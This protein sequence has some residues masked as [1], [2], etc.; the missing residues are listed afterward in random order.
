[1]AA[2]VD[3]AQQVGIKL[4]VEALDEERRG[5]LP[6]REPAQQSRHHLKRGCVATQRRV[7]APAISRRAL[8]ATIA[9][10]LLAAVKAPAGPIA[11]PRFGF[12]EVARKAEALAG[13][14]YTP[15][16]PL[17]AQVGTWSY[18]DYRRIQ[19]KL[20]RTLW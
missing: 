2:G 8:I 4:S 9:G 15:G 17:P 10:S 7:V 19:F 3:L 16:P 1:M 20:E 13:R 5:D 11:P 18:E 14:G 6:L 12:R